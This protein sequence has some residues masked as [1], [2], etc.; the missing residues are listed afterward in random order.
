MQD[1]ETQKKI[2]NDEEFNNKLKELRLPVPVCVSCDVIADN[3]NYLLGT[4]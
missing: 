3:L 1:I 2:K 4:I